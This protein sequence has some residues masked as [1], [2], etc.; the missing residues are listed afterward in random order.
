MNSDLLIGLIAEGKHLGGKYVYYRNLT[1]ALAERQAPFV[2]IRHRPVPRFSPRRVASYVLGRLA[3][4]RRARMVDF[5]LNAKARELN[6]L[7]TRPTVFHTQHP[8]ASVT[9]ARSALRDTPIVQT[10]HSFW[11]I[12]C[13]ALGLAADD[14]LLRKYR[15][16]QDEALE[17]TDLFITL[18]R[19]QSRRLAEYGVEPERI[20]QI[21]N[22]VDPDALLAT[23]RPFR[24]E[25]GYVVV[26]SRLSPE[27][28]TEVAI[29]AIAAIPP[30]ERPHL[31]I[32]GEGP[33]GKALVDLALH[34]KLE[35]HVRF[36]GVR[37][38]DET[39]GIMRGA[40]LV[41]CPS[42]PYHGIEDS[43][44]LT[45]LEAMAVGTPVAASRVG[46][47]PEY[48]EDGVTGY[49]FEPGDGSAL[50]S[51]IREHRQRD[52]ERRRQMAADC[53]A[54][55][56]RCFEHWTDE[57]LDAYRSVLPAARR[58]SAA[59]TLPSCRPSL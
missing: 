56:A 43:A 3:G 34:L 14:E 42:V 20:V 5:E 57:I 52:G 28:G 33:A 50:A 46:G 54:A 53:R 13:Q 45:I 24:H 22:A 59:D 37:D 23:S 38:H 7:R 32:L 6:R 15:A 26:A 12:E 17:R 1:G 11:L 48:V 21:P 35:D 39:V 10:V 44:P 9:I 18:N 29:E 25:P 47:I 40:E 49:L 2:E 8:F 4:D 31:L 19:L 36:L 51:V 27:K 58:T 55:M 16:I 41:L 30:Q